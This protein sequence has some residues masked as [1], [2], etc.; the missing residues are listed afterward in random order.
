MEWYNSDQNGKLLNAE[1]AFTLKKCL[2]VL[3]Y[4]TEVYNKI[5]TPTQF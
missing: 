5:T 4:N 2:K 1:I 3:H